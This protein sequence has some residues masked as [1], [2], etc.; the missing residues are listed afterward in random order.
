MRGAERIERALAALGEAGQSAAGPQGVDAVAAAGED[1]VRIGLVA[2]VPDQPVARR[3][4]DIMQRHGQFDDAQPRAEM[5]AGLRH[6]ANGFGPQLVSDRPEFRG[7]AK[8]QALR[9]AD[10]VELHRRFLLMLGDNAHVRAKVPRQVHIPSRERRL[11]PHFRLRN[12]ASAHSGNI[13]G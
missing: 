4:E 3:V 1:L 9:S 12:R 10:V 7:A 8:L 2:D 5:A 13:F 6:R 11:S